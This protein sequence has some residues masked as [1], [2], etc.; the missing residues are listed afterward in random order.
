MIAVTGATGNVGRALVDRLLAAGHPVRALTRDPKRA[1]LPERAE[2]VE[3]RPEEPA[4]LFEG[5]SAVFLY[6]QAVTEPLLAAARAAGARHAVLLSSGI[7]QEGADETHPIH[8]LHANAERLIRDSGLEWT[9]LRPNGFATN[10]L[11]WAPQ[12][13]AGNTVRGVYADAVAAPIHEDD[14]AAVA[15]RV[16]LDDGHEGAVHRLTGPAAATNAD[17]VAAIGA[18]VGREL[19]F[20]EIDPAAAGPQLFPYLDAHMLDRLLKTFEATIGV[21]P[22]ITDTVERIT[23]TPARTFARWARDHAADFGADS[24]A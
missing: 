5:A 20:V 14:I 8:V 23:G 2:V 21:T 12:I 15:E 3:F 11:Q 4:A 24:A 19:T 18:A 13:R 16:L 6:A 22:E 7:V 10:A 1:A 9:F 17:Q